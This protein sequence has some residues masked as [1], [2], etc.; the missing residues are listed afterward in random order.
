VLA[1]LEKGS[2]A[3]TFTRTEAAAAQRAKGKGGGKK[4]S[5]GGPEVVEAEVVD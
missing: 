5:G 4:K 1:H 3:L 2:E